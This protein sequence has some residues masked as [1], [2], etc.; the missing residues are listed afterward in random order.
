MGV[1]D[2]IIIWDTKKTKKEIFVKLKKS[3][4]NER[5]Q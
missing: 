1:S 5:N 2:L 3:R 4:Q